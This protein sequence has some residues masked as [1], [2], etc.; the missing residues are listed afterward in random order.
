MGTRDLNDPFPTR[1]TVSLPSG[2]Y[3]CNR[4]DRTFRV[5]AELRIACMDNFD[6]PRVGIC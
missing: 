1:A 5:P 2:P 4:R 3:R 6:S